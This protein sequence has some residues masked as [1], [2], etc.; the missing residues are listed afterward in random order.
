M[1]VYAPYCDEVL[2]CWTLGHLVQAA[3]M[4]LRQ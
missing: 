1:D 3:D 2:E 4:L